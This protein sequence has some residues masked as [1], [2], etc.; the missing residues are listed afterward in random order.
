M[1]FS[2]LKENFRTEKQI[3][4]V[5]RSPMVTPGQKKL[6]FQTFGFEMIFTE[7]MQKISQNR[8][9]FWFCWSWDKFLRLAIGFSVSYLG[10]GP[11]IGS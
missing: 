2:Q 10:S 9:E 8:F 3:S 6:T 5:L 1:D 11:A 4:N 7:T